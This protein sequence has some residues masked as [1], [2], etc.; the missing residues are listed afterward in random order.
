M[1]TQ[2]SAKRRLHATNRRIEQNDVKSGL[3]FTHLAN[4][5]NREENLYIDT[6]NEALRGDNQGAAQ[7]NTFVEFFNRQFQ[8]RQTDLELKLLLP[9]ILAHISCARELMAVVQ[10]QNPAHLEAVREF[11]TSLRK[12]ETKLH[13]C[14]AFMS[15]YLSTNKRLRPA[16][17]MNFSNIGGRNEMMR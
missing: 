14:R 15:R 4:N 11:E 6:Y 9:P 13:N 3:I 16:L 1:Y 10:T 12:A 2:Q 5:R 7:L 8:P 17:F